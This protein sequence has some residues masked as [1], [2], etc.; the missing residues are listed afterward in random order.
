[1]GIG[2]GERG[3]REYEEAGRIPIPFDSAWR[4]GAFASEPA[5][6]SGAELL[7]GFGYRAFTGSSFPQMK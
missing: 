2:G 3:E 7:T 5:S 6:G 1:M 4:K